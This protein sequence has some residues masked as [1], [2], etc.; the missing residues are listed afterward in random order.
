MENYLYSLYKMVLK[1]LTF[2][3][4]VDQEEKRVGRHPKVS[5]LQLCVL[6]ILSYITNT[7]ISTVAKSLID[8][9]SAR[10]Q[11]IKRFSGKAFWGKKKWEALGLLEIG[12]IGVVSM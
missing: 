5:D 8:S 6:F 4:G 9:N 10:T 2:Y 3:L 11:K 12:D 1:S 7:S